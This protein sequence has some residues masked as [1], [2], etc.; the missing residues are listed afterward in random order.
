MI[1]KDLA[2]SPKILLDFAKPEAVTFSNSN[3][4]MLKDFLS[5]FFT[6]LPGYQNPKILTQSGH[7][8]VMLTQIE[9][10]D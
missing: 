4:V 7:L 5:D 8:K 9:R 6:A 2:V 3:D 10:F 1:N